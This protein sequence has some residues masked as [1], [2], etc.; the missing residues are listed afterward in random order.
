MLRVEQVQQAIKVL[1]DDS[2]DLFFYSGD[3]SQANIDRFI[4][5]L[6]AAKQCRKRT[7]VSLIL[8]TNGGDAHQAYRLARLFQDLYG[9][10]DN[11]RLV[12]QGRCKSAGTLVA[13]GAG[14]LAMG[15]FG[16]LG[17]LDVQLAK[18]DEIAVRTSGL[19][20]LGAL[21]VLQAEAFNAFEQ[22]LIKIIN[23]SGHTVSTKTACDIASNMVSGLLRPIASQIDPHRLSEV[24]RM[25]RIAKSYGE[26]LGTPNLKDREAGSALTRLIRGYPTHEYIIDRKEAGEIFEMVTEPSVAELLVCD[27]YLGRVLYPNSA[28]DATIIDVIEQFESIAGPGNPSADQGNPAG[29]GGVACTGSSARTG[30]RPSETEV[31][32]KTDHSVAELGPNGVER[33]S[34]PLRDQ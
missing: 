1:D 22:Y 18:L 24:E 15:I 13:M 5:I 6:V 11:F 20:T 34:R 17:P 25:M 23:R 19:D 2:R 33:P 31:D 4:S 32:R 26:R 10:A 16:E 30:G 27:L 21:A 14:E 9:G 3:I 12:V 8:T 7:K 28:E 29:T